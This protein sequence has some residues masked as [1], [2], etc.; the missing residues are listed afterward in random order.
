MLPPIKDDLLTQAARLPGLQPR[1]SNRD[2]A[3]LD[4]TA[5]TEPPPAAPPVQDRLAQL[6]A[7]DP[8]PP[9]TGRIADKTFFDELSG[10][11]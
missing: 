9:P 3:G 8:L 7:R 5:K 1:R 11:S 10:D 6:W 2:A 4:A